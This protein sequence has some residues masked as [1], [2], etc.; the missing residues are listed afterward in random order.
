[1]SYPT[2]YPFRLKPLGQCTSR[3]NS[4]YLVLGSC[5][6]RCPKFF[7]LFFYA[8]CLHMHRSVQGLTRGS[9]PQLEKLVPASPRWQMG[10]LPP[11]THGTA[12]GRVLALCRRMAVGRSS[13]TVPR[14]GCWLP[15]TAVALRRS[16]VRPERRMLWTASRISALED[17]ILAQG[18]LFMDEAQRATLALHYV[19]L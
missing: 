2:P 12:H 3:S 8:L 11:R 5:T 10:L 16:G 19:D 6:L 1:M 18:A 13:M 14:R 9:T 4:T 15:T 17:Q 7:F